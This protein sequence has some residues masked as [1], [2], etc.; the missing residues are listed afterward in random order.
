MD[1]IA[2]EQ[3]N[4]IRKD[5][6]IIRVAREAFPIPSDHA[7]AAN[8]VQVIDVDVLARTA[9]GVFD[10]EDSS[11]ACFAVAGVRTRCRC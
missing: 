10:A 8:S 9:T 1:S 2:L 11:L 3:S 5:I 6:N 7:C 4:R